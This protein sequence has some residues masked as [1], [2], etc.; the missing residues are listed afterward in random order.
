MNLFIYVFFHP[1]IHTSISQPSFIPLA[2]SPTST[3]SK[4][5]VHPSYHSSIHAPSRR[6]LNDAARDQSIWR[7][8][9]EPPL[10]LKEFPYLASYCTF[11]YNLSPHKQNVVIIK[12]HNLCGL[13]WYINR[14]IVLQ[15]MHPWRNGTFILYDVNWQE[16]PSNICPL[17]LQFRWDDS[18]LYLWTLPL[19]LC[20]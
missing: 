4:S 6:G 11:W 3:T 2:Y 1:S 18:L 14:S 7:R 8:V 5:S 13:A 9:E 20:A 15:A 17:S 19:L 10:L 16:A 12:E